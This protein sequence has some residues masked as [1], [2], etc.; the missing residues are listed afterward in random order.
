[1]TLRLPPRL[2][3]PS[4]V[5]LRALVFNPAIPFPRQR[6]RSDAVLRLLH[7]VPR[8]TEV[9]P[10]ELAGTRGVRFSSPGADPRRRVIYLHGGAFCVGSSVMGQAFSARL[11]RAAGVVVYSLD[12]RRAPEHPPPAALEDVLALYR[13]L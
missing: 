2:V 8:G 3:S 5:L 7:H 1:M 10:F 12:Y 9:A 13:H 4:L 6:A 11:S